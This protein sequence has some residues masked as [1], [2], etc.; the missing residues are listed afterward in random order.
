MSSRRA[1]RSS[2]NLLPLH[3]SGDGRWCISEAPR[4]HT[5]PSIDWHRRTRPLSPPPPVIV[6]A[7]V[8]PMTTTKCAGS[9]D[10]A[11]TIPP[12]GIQPRCQHSQLL[13]TRGRPQVPCC[14]IHESPPSIMDSTCPPRYSHSRTF[15]PSSQ[16]LTPCTPR[17][18]PDPE[19]VPGEHTDHC[20]QA[21]PR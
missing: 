13:N 20:A 5:G 10:Y 11:D 7:A 12:P 9:S 8:S 17:E 3:H 6:A 4:S 1:I 14:S 15:Q 19:A 2:S 16:P 18:L 21:V